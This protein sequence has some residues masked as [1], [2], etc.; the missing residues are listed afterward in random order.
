MG[1]F[2][3]LLG[4]LAR[5]CQEL[6]KIKAQQTQDHER[7]SRSFEK[8][9][10]SI[11]KQ[12]QS[13]LNQVEEEH[14]HLR[15][16]LTCIQKENEIALQNG[17]C[18]INSMVHK[19]CNVS[20]HLKQALVTSINNQQ[21][22]RQIQGTLSDIFSKKSGINISLKKVHF[23]PRPLQTTTL[24]EIRCEEQ[25]LGF[26]IPIL[27]KRMESQWCK[28]ATNKLILLSDET[29]PWEDVSQHPEDY[30]GEKMED[31]QESV[32]TTTNQS[33]VD[34][35]F[36]HDNQRLSLSSIDPAVMEADGAALS[37]QVATKIWIADSKN[38]AQRLNKN[39]QGT[40]AMVA[41]GD[42]VGK[43]TI[44]HITSKRAKGNSRKEICPPLKPS[45]KR[46]LRSPGSGVR[47]ET[48][49][50]LESD[51][52]SN[53]Q[54]TID[55]TEATTKT[56]C[57]EAGHKVA[58]SER[59]TLFR[60]TAAYVCE[61]ESESSEDTMEDVETTDARDPKACRQLVI[62]DSR[63]PSAKKQSDG[64]QVIRWNSVD[65]NSQPSESGDSTL[66]SYLNK[67][68]L[69][70]SST[71]GAHRMASDI[72]YMRMSDETSDSLSGDF[73]NVP[74]RPC[75]PSESVT[76]SNTFIIEFP[77]KKP[78]EVK[79]GTFT[80]SS[81]LLNR[82]SRR[83]PPVITPSTEKA[84]V[85]A[86]QA[87]PALPD[88]KSRPTAKVR[89]PVP[90]SS[91]M[92]YI[93][94]ASRPHTA[95]SRSKRP[96]SAKERRDSVSSSS[97]T[98]SNPRSVAAST[99]SGPIREIRV[100]VKS[101]QYSRRLPK[102]SHSRS[103]SLSQSALNLT[104]CPL[105]TGGDGITK[106]V[107]QFG[108]FGSG[109]AEL[110]LPHGICATSSGSIYIVDYGNRRLQ[111]MDTKGKL[112]QQFG[113]EA[114]NYFDVAVS[115][116]GLVAL[117]NS[118][119][120]SVDVYSKHGRLLQVLSRNWGAPRGITAN[121][122]DEFIVADMK[123]D[124][125]CALTLDCSTGRQKESKVVPGFNKP[126]LVGT[127]GQGLLAVSERGLDGG[128]CV[129]VLGEDWQLL[130]VLGLKSSPGPTLFNPWGVCVDSGGGVLVADWAQAHSIIYYPT[131]SPARVIVAGG[132]SSP[133]GLALWQDGL[134][135]VA[136]SMHNCIKL[137]QYQDPEE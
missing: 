89:N 21:V 118:T 12:E 30:V 90:R 125:I 86:K 16:Q 79:S 24:G 71:Q 96:T 51:I 22:M 9:L 18:E 132:L 4:D 105:G 66:I 75:S 23:T 11:L 17:V 73:L 126:Y 47:K 26:S 135:M 116:R 82:E 109:R 5:T 134:V 56:V 119:D 2:A 10:L 53:L 72:D 107:R 95:P 78:P 15:D 94:R 91:S 39:P 131:R 88:G 25:S 117:T 50:K 34:L 35:R 60:A 84:Q 111:V 42:P 122:R 70:S 127:N 137:F 85:K 76:S 98:W 19:I 68:N 3:A 41:N 110:N 124:T 43:S 128:C 114:K 102:T 93:E 55:T 33:S 59:D 36:P 123:L 103:R 37:P 80:R 63:V 108:K 106:L 61:D 120:R 133:R 64:E 129:K 136:D 58:P 130:K 104:D 69:E 8:T 115:N 81:N 67:Q 29:P 99:P 52:L 121:N 46:Q 1:D 74:P 6:E 13:I 32:S 97:S 77:K 44:Q 40:R 113:L 27:N 101:A 45:T 7:V 65:S 100:R 20:S 83:K 31:D 28:K 49:T 62:R 14:R 38:T 87:N 54:E 48:M 57:E 112:L 92:P